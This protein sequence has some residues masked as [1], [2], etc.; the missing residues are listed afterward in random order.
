MAIIYENKNRRRHQ[1]GEAYNDPM[2]TVEHVIL[3]EKF[4]CERYF[5]DSVVSAFERM[6]PFLIR[7]EEYTWQELL[8]EEHW[9]DMVGLPSHLACLC[10]KHMADQPDAPFSLHDYGVA[11]FRIR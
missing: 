4:R 3:L 5:Y 10:L 7:G 2:D 9:S 6:R 8:G 11:Y 1:R